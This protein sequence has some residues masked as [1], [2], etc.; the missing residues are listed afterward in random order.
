MGIFMKGY[1][2]RIFV[3]S[4]LAIA[5]CAVVVVPAQSE[6]PPIPE[7][8]TEIPPEGGEFDAGDS[9][10]EPEPAEDVLLHCGNCADD[11]CIE[12]PADSPDATSCGEANPAEAMI[13]GW[14]A[15]PAGTKCTIVKVGAPWCPPCIQLGNA[16]PDV[17]L[18]FPK[19]YFIDFNKDKLADDFKNTLQLGN[20]IPVIRIYKYVDG[21]PQLIYTKVGLERSPFADKTDAQYT[22]SVIQDILD[23][24]CK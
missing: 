18:Q 11:D 1:V 20:L 10:S 7:N 14:P 8:Y 13:T 9:Y 22:A 3:C 2:K 4:L 17:L 16:L 15:T 21:Q 6:E 12:T 19:V 23:Q 5:L 24:H